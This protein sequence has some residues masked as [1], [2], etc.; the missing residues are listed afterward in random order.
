L[1]CDFHFRRGK[2]GKDL[3][4]AASA[5]GSINRHLVFL[6][7]GDRNWRY[8]PLDKMDEITPLRK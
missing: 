6:S 2:Q 5:D 3:S 7:S 4:L 1:E 8:F